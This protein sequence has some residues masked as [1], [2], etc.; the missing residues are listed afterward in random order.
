[1]AIIS[2]NLLRDTEMLIVSF[3]PAKDLVAVSGIH[4]N[5][6]VLFSN[7]P[8]FRD[9][10]QQL[11]SPFLQKCTTLEK[12]FGYLCSTHPSNC[13]KVAYCFLQ[14][15][16]IRG[17]FTQDFLNE[18]TITRRRELEARLKEICGE[19][20][21]DPSSPIHQAWLAYKEQDNLLEA[22]CATEEFLL[23]KQIMIEHGY[24]STERLLA[25]LESTQDSHSRI[26]IIAQF[27]KRLLPFV[28]LQKNYSDLLK[29]TEALFNKYR[30]LENKRVETVNSI[31]NLNTESKNYLLKELEEQRNDIYYYSTI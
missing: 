11:Y 8:Y 31:Q 18:G 12:K 7:N 30:L 29:K 17:N 2:S 4:T 24:A 19:F 15:G 3:L 28:E 23:A 1:M 10:L 21:E 22:L 25:T 27:D 26:D 14:S 5:A 16:V 6:Y 13:W 20:Y 9:L